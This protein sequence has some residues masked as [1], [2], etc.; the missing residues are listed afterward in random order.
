MIPADGCDRSFRL[1]PSLGFEL[2]NQ[3]CVVILCG[4]HY[5]ASGTL[6]SGVGWTEQGHHAL[7]RILLFGLY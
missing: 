2:R 7:K 4:A 5:F 6:A 1:G 3:A